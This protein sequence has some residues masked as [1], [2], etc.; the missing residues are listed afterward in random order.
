MVTSRSAV[1]AICGL[2]FVLAIPMVLKL[3]PPN[4]AYGFRT[5]QTFA[6]SAAWYK[7]NFF[8][9]AIAMLV[10]IAAAAAVYFLPS[11]LLAR[12][13]S[14]PMALLIVGILVIILGSTFYAASL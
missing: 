1:Y 7:G 6:S 2:I 13:P 8:A 4:S 9:G 10:S 3:V 12:Y 11:S 5:A 14:L